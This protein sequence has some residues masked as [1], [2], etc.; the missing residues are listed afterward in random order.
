MG[1]FPVWGFQ[2]L[3]TVALAIPLKLNKAIALIAANISVP[4]IIPFIIY[5]SFLMGGLILGGSAIPEFSSDLS[6]ADIKDDLLQYY[7]GA[8][9]LSIVFG[10]STGIISWFL[11]EKWRKPPV[12]LSE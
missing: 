2:M 1:I 11:L 5:F 10:L 7:L 6:F 12:K 8:V 3:I 9:V 4:P